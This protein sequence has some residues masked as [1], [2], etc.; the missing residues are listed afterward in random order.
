[1]TATAYECFDLSE[2]GGVA[3]LTFSRPH[4]RNAM[5]PSFW[6]DLPKV[7]RALSDGGETRALVIDAQ[8]PHFC[9]GMD[10]AVFAGG[11]FATDTPAR[12]EAFARAAHPLQDAL[13]VLE[14]AR[15]PVI[16]AIQGGCIGGAVDMVCAADLRFAS[17]DA[18]FRIEEINI[19]MMADVGTLQRMPKLIPEAVVR[20]LAYTG[21]TLDAARALAVGFVNGLEPTHEAVVERALAVARRIAEKPPLAVTASKMAITYSRDHSVA[22]S[23]R[24]ALTLQGAVWSPQDIG[25]A[26]TARAER[27]TGVYAPLAPITSLTDTD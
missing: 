22:D 8:G 19:G 1:M 18:V 25:E 21:D 2:E 4:K 3:R 12:R 9:A 20:E 5:S 15:F 7:V 24:Y 11:G 14:E 6:T 17:T 10:V 23:L 26:M 27:R 13:T 16:C